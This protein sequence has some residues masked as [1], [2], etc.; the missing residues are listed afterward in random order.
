MFTDDITRVFG[1]K[2][3]QNE[4]EIYAVIDENKTA[5]FQQGLS[6]SSITNF[7]GINSKTLLITKDV[8]QKD[9]FIIDDKSYRIWSFNPL[10]LKG[11]NFS[12]EVIIYEDD[13]NNE[14]E[15]FA[16]SIQ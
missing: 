6:N 11:E 5:P 4:N 7:T 2:I 8:N 9:I 10:G 15:F 16:Q 12:N 1:H 3:L 14:I 13:F